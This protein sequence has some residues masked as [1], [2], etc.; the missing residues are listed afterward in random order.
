LLVRCPSYNATYSIIN[1]EQT[2]TTIGFQELQTDKRNTYRKKVADKAT[3]KAGSPHDG[4]EERGIE[5]DGPVEEGRDGQPA[6]KKAKL[7]ESGDGIAQG[8]EEEQSEEIEEEEEEGGEDGEE[9]EAERDDA[10]EVEDM[11][12]RDGEEEDEGLDNGEDSD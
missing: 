9:E 4:E 7:S 10:V 1:L 3:G 2:D 5:G 6:A 12:E 11:E 8:D